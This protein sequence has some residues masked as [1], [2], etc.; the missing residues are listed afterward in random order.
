MQLPTDGSSD[1]SLHVRAARALQATG[2]PMTADNLNAMM[3]RMAN[4]QPSMDEGVTQNSQDELLATLMERTD[5]PPKQA[6][7]PMRQAPAAQAA[8]AQPTAATTAQQPA[9]AAAPAKSNG[10]KTDDLLKEL[11]IL[12]V[13]GAATAVIAPK[14][15]KAGIDT[16]EKLRADP[17]A[18]KMVKEA[19]TPAPASAIDK[20]A[21]QTGMATDPMGNVQGGAA[22]PETANMPP[23]PQDTYGPHQPGK[24]PPT[25]AHNMPEEPKPAASK[26]KDLKGELAKRLKR[27]AK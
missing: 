15:L 16:P 3:D 25:E 2:A 14:L 8:P 26:G 23:A 21:A 10:F 7:A 22:A 24:Q 18:L 12:G 4:A 20:F 1:Q 5:A 6:A 27:V 17:E 19:A 13:A 9:Q 11:A